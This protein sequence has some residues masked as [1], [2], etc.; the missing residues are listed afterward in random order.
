L[1]PGPPPLCPV[2][3]ELRPTKKKIKIYLEPEHKTQL[4]NFELFAFAL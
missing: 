3:N 4:R 2:I 1:R